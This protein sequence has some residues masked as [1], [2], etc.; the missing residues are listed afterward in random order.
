MIRKLDKMNEYPG[1]A[2][3]MVMDADFDV[4]YALHKQLNWFPQRP[5]LQWVPS[6]QDDDTDDISS[7]T[8]AAQLN[9]HADELATLGLRNLLPSPI[10]P[11]DPTT[12]VQ[13]HHATG[14]ITKKLMPTVRSFCQL[15]ALKS[16]YLCNFKWTRKDFDNIDWII[17]TPVYTKHSK[18]YQAFTHKYAMR[19]LPTGSRMERNG[20]NEESQCSTCRQAHED[21][22][23][24]FQCPKRPAYRKKILEALNTI[25]K[26]MCPILYYLF[27]TSTLNYIDGHDRSM[28]SHPMISPDP[29]TLDEYNTLLTQQ[30]RIGWDHL[31]RGKL[32]VLWRVYQRQYECQQR[33][34]R[35][36]PSAHNTNNENNNNN[37]DNENNNKD[38]A[39]NNDTDSNNLTKNNNTDENNNSKPKPK[40]KRNTDRF[41]QFINLAFLAARTELWIDRCN[42]RHRRVEGNCLAL[43]TKVNRDVEDL[44][45][46]YEQTRYDDRQIFYELTLE[47]RLRLPT[48]RKQQW[49]KR[50][51][52]NIGTSIIRATNDTTRDTTEI[53]KYFN[54][55]KRPTRKINKRR[56]QAQKRTYQRQRA[57]MPIE[58][59]LYT[60]NGVTK[61]PTKSTSKKPPETIPIRMSNP[62][63]TQFFQ[64]KIDDRYP[65]EWNDITPR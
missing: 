53:Y 36:T 15:P 29:N 31:L 23:H 44:Y 38:N 4:L 56:L 9:I 35:R 45:S 39:N 42:D 22:D 30:A 10:V 7:L 52:Q 58:N 33:M 25:K 65:D 55:A 11:M 48:Y 47:E 5:H 32:S 46:K 49:I 28:A 2:R 57:S 61:R 17:F 3:S 41:Q 54:C 64:R 43:D 40:K 63:I 34:K 24:L 51:K 59:K 27:S 21:D 8:P 18:K 60:F 1:A 6:H 12:H 50:W 26:G 14:T 20:G 62:P 16:Y 19:K 13:I 37:N